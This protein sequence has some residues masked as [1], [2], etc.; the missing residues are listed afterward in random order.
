MT[1]MMKM[2]KTMTTIMVVVIQIKLSDLHEL[3]YCIWMTLRNSA[4]H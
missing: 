1:T 4:Q 3:D 2:M